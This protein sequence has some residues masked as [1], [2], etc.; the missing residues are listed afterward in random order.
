MWSDG[1][2]DWG[3]NG[4][5]GKGSDRIARDSFVI[6]DKVSNVIFDLVLMASL[7]RFCWDRC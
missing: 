6:S 7:M 1:I 3:F 2:P 4:I 5:I